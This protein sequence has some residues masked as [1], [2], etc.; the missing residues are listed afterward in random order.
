[1]TSEKRQGSPLRFGG[2]GK[3]GGQIGAFRKRHRENLK[4]NRKTFSDAQGGDKKSSSLR[5]LSSKGKR[6]PA[7]KKGQEGNAMGR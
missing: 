7:K 1:V 3:L 5:G 2:G 4:I 6:G